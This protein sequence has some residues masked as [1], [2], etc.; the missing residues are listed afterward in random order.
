LNGTRC[1]RRLWIGVDIGT[2][3]VRAAAFDD[4]G[5][6]VSEKQIERRPHAPASGD[7]VHDAERDWWEAVA[8]VIRGI[9]PFPNPELVGGIAVSGLFPAVV[10]VAADGRP[11]SDGIL[12]GDHRTVS[13]VRLLEQRLDTPLRGDEVVAKLVWLKATNPDGWAAARYALGPTGYVTLRLTGKAT[14]D[15][16]S[17]ARWGPLPPLGIQGWPARWAEE[18]GIPT[19]MLPELKQSTAL[20]GGVSNAA[21]EATGLPVGTPV[22]CGTTDTMATLLGNNVCS[23][24]DAMVYYGSTGTLSTCQV[25]LYEWLATADA[26]NLKSPYTLSAYCV[27]MGLFLADLT[28]AMYGSSNFSQADAEAEALQPGAGGVLAYLPKGRP[29]EGGGP[30]GGAFLGLRLG[31]ERGHLWRALLESFG[32]EL[33]EAQESLETELRRVTAAGRGATSEVWRQIVSD[34]TGWEQE[35]R[36][37]AAARGAAALAA[38]AS[39]VRGSGREAGPGWALGRIASLTRPRR[40]YADPYRQLLSQWRHGARALDR[41]RHHGYGYHRDE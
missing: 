30:A 18:L 26:V 29:A 6:V 23:P 16:H 24:G 35:L 1:D 13:E 32:F 38:Y 10:L 28:E 37:A 4:E 34:M 15:P 19:A 31:H 25:H 2:Q 17:A 11:L 22:A 14:I 7:M 40:Q 39:G 33:M 8:A 21:A 41:R 3:G 9:G 27:N 20:I 12:Y 5:R 36:G